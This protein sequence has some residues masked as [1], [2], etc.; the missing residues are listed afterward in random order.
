VAA[1]LLVI[2]GTV[3]AAQPIY[4]CGPDG[5][6]YSDVPCP[7][8][9]SVAVDDARTPEQR[10]QAEAVAGSMRSLGDALERD[11][12]QRDAVTPVPIKRVAAASPAASASTRSH[13][14][15]K[16]RQPDPNAPAKYVAPRKAG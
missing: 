9:R 4:R 2:V 3:H 12:L 1:V 16:R 15:K 13:G 8:G 11:R 7:D 14:K 5:R 6:I 10:R